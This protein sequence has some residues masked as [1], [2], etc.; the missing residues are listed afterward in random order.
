MSAWRASVEWL[1][2]EMAHMHQRVTLSLFHGRRRHT[3][4]SS[5][6]QGGLLTSMH[7]V[8]HKR[9][10][11]GQRRMVKQRPAQGLGEL[12]ALRCAFGHPFSSPVRWERP[13][14]VVIDKTKLL[15]RASW[16]QSPIRLHRRRDCK[17][18]CQW[19]TRNKYGPRRLTER[20]QCRINSTWST[21]NAWDR[22]RTTSG[23]IAMQQRE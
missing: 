23:S 10:R 4:S 15:G 20:T 9:D 7:S 22:K 17:N 3:H 8:V 11:S 6:G 2:V 1:H 5:H 12:Q 19:G 13:V 18:A 16:S 21:A 14:C